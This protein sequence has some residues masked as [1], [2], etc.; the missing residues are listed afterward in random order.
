MKCEK[1]S[2]TNEAV[3]SKL[4][5]TTCGADMICLGSSL[6]IKPAC[7]IAMSIRMSKGK[8]IRVGTHYTNLDK[9]SSLVINAEP[10]DVI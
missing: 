9:V 1:A 5:F 2:Y 4:L 6:N 8:F 10:D 3:D 7:S